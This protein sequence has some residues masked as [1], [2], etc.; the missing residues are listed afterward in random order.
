MKKSNES[1]LARQNKLLRAQIAKMQAD[2]LRLYSDLQ[3]AQR[4]LA[5]TR[6]LI[7]LSPSESM[8]EENKRLAL[9]NARW[10]KDL[11]GRPEVIRTVEKISD[12]PLVGLIREIVREEMGDVERDCCSTGACLSD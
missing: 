2:Y 1:E 9:E 4:N 8:V 12:H 10:K 7:G 5:G 11:A 3:A 6:V